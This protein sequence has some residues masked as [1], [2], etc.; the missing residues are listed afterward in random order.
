MHG[1]MYNDMHNDMPNDMHN[2]MCRHEHLHANMHDHTY[3]DMYDDMRS[4]VCLGFYGIES[5]VL[6]SSFGIRL[7]RRWRPPPTPKQALSCTFPADEPPY[8]RNFGAGG[9]RDP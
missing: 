6:R 1:N 3:K 8:V 9:A 7:V 4:N 5:V 2:G